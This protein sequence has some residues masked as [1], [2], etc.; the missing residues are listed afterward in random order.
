MR[1]REPDALAAVP[2]PAFARCPVAAQFHRHGDVFQRSQRRDQLEIL[3]NKSDELIANSRPFI[4]ADL[5]QRNAIQ[6]HRTR[7]RKIEPRAQSQQRR[8]STAGWAE[9]GTGR[10][11]L[12]SERN[13]F[14]DG[15]FGRATSVNLSSGPGR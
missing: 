6:Q 11:F 15:Q 12:E 7:S 1:S 5:A 14:Q 2:R 3:K 10:P 13:I 9:N 8:L 4:F